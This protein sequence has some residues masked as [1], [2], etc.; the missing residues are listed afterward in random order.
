MSL[1]DIEVQFREIANVLKNG[2]AGYY[3]GSGVPQYNVI[4][5]SSTGTT[6]FTIPHRTHSIKGMAV[7]GNVYGLYTSAWS[8]AGILFTNNAVVTLFHGTPIDMTTFQVFVLNG[9][10]ATL[11]LWT[12]PAPALS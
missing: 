4:G 12:I 2:T 11:A 10:S 7:G 5:L 9:V 1:K 8:G 3:L 6:P